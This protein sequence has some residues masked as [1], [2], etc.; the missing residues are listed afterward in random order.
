MATVKH[1]EQR[2]PQCGKKLDS[3]TG[4]EEHT[5]P[6]EGD[7]S[8]CIGCGAA[9]EYG[10]GLKLQLTTIEAIERVSPSAA[11]DLRRAKAALVAMRAKMN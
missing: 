9:F 2:C 4:L 1:A 11:D 7:F 8:M 3:S 5:T 10:E 6:S